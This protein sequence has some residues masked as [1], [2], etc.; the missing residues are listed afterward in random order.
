[1]KSNNKLVTVDLSD[2]PQIYT[3]GQSIPFFTAISLLQLITWLKS[4][5]F[6]VFDWDGCLAEGGLET[7]N[8]PR[9][10]LQYFAENERTVKYFRSLVLFFAKLGIQ[11][12]ICTGR[13]ADFI[14]PHLDKLFPKGKI[15]FLICEGGADLYLYDPKQRKFVQHKPDYVSAIDVQWFM[16]RKEKI[17]E[18]CENLGAVL[19]SGK[20]VILS[21]NTPP[22]WKITL[23]V[24]MS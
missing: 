2:S 24:F 18:V 19:E 1:M 6:F 3:L 14:I 16:E 15:A 9:T 10:V 8:N 20:K 23:K 5:Q 22:E 4:L 13:S 11:F 12:G 21:F 7:A 17:R